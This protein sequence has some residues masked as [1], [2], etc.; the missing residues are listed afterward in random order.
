MGLV[1]ECGADYGTNEH[2][3]ATQLFVKKDQRQMFLTLPSNKIRF[4]WLTRMYNKFKKWVYGYI[5][6]MY[7]CELFLFTL[8]V[9]VD[10]FHLTYVLLCTSILRLNYVCNVLNNVIFR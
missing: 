5:C 8:C 7:G 9:V 10:Y 4:N 2:F 6:L 1:L 3:V